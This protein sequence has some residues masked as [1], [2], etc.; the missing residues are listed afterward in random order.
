MTPPPAP[1]VVVGDRVEQLALDLSRSW[2]VARNHFLTG[3]MPVNSSSSASHTRVLVG[4]QGVL[5]RLLATMSKP[6][7]HRP[8]GDGQGHWA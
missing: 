4:S 2:E 8:C 1:T 5:P 7:L 3:E 6:G